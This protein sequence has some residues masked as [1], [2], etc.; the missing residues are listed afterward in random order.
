M[1]LLR[2]AVRGI[3]DFPKAGI[4]FYDITPLLQDARAFQTAVDV[5]S[6]RYVGAPVDVILGIDARGFLLAP[7][8]AY[9]LGKGLAI[10]RKRGKLPSKTLQASYALEYGEAVLEMH[11]DAVKPGQRV[12]IVDDVLATG[13]TADAAG[14]LIKSAG[15]IVHEYCFLLE[16]LALGGRDRLRDPVY[17]VLPYA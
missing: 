10:V 6:D 17:S 11:A 13:G 9:K 15:G 1:E 2:N 12:L 16:L 7:A 3:P 14:R 4:F 5:M 8:I